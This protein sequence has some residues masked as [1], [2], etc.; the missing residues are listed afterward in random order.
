MLPATKKSL[1]TH[2]HRLLR[3]APLLLLHHRRMVPLHPKVR[4]A[5]VVMPPHPSLGVEDVAAQADV[6]SEAMVLTDT[7]MDREDIPLDDTVAR[8]FP[9][10]EVSVAGASKKAPLPST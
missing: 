8:A 5:L 6:T 1:S 3:T 9:S 7:V 10:G 4:D 2:H